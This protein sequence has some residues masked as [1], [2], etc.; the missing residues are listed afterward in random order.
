MLQAMSSAMT[1]AALASY[2]PQ[3]DAAARSA[4]R[5]WS[6]EGRVQAQDAVKTFAFNLA[7]E[8]V[9]G[10]RN[11]GADVVSSTGSHGCLETV[12]GFRSSAAD[13]VSSTGSVDCSDMGG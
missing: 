10:F 9:C 3:M 13:M 1:P 4:C 11:S 6:A 2:V 5:Q 12:C 8:I 7:M